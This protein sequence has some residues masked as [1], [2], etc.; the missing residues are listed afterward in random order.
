MMIV[1]DAFNTVHSSLI[2]ETTCSQ[3]GTPYPNLR[4]KLSLFGIVKTISSPIAVM[5]RRELSITNVIIMTINDFDIFR[6]FSSMILLVVGDCP[7]GKDLVLVTKMI[8][9]A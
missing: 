2:G 3:V 6:V 9:W 4:V 5:I 8:L 1:I 7:L